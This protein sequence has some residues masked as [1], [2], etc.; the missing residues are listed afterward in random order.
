MSATFLSEVR[1]K[2]FYNREIAAKILRQECKKYYNDEETKYV[3]QKSFQKIKDN[4]HMVLWDELSTEERNTIV[5]KEVQ[6][7][8]V[9]RVVFKHSLSSPALS[10]FDGSSRTKPRPDGSSEA[11]IWISAWLHCQMR[12]LSLLLH[13]TA[14]S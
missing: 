11:N 14:A 5:H 1:R 6:H 9:W 10:V 12:V 7:Y 13:S 8:I 2:D 3:I 4:G